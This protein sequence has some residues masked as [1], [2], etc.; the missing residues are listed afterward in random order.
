MSLRY[1]YKLQPTNQ[2]I[3][4]LRGR[5][6]R[7]RPIIT[8]AVL[9]PTGSQVE[10]ALLDTGA[11]DTVFP[12]DLARQLGIDLTNAP[13]GGG[14]GVGMVPAPLRYA[15]VSLRIASGG[16][17]R[18]WRAWVGFTSARLK[19]PLLG[20]AGFLQFFT[21]TFHGHREEVELTV[22]GLYPGT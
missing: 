17:R 12:E 8:L 11:D 18:E 2:P 10:T 4:S 7:P 16:E 22:N 1:A 14:A 21:A 3:P 5:Q 19:R 6:V 20:F 15:E 13:V 9:G